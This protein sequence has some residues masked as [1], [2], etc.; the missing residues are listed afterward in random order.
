MFKRKKWLRKDYAGELFPHFN[1]QKASFGFEKNEKQL[2]F[3]YNLNYDNYK[4]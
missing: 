2:S 3:T 1:Q 4:L